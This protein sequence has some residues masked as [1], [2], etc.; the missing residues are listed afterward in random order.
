[1]LTVNHLPV[2]ACTCSCAPPHWAVRDLEAVLGRPLMQAD[3]I[4]WEPDTPPEP[5]EGDTAD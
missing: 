1:V 3:C 4:R 5:K 2:P